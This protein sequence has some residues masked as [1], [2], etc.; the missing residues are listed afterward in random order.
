MELC[1]VLDHACNLRCR[2]C[3]TGSKTPRP[4]SADVVRKAIDLALAQHTGWLSITLFGGEPLLT[5]GILHVVEAI[6]EAALRAHEHPVAL[7]WSLDTNGTRL[8]ESALAWLAPPRRATVFVSFDG[9][10]VVHDANRIDARGRGTHRHVVEGIRRMRMAGIPFEIVAVVGPDTAN[11]LGSSL[12]AMFELQ[13]ARISLQANLYA[14]WDGRSLSD[15]DV[16]LAQAVEVWANEFRRGRCPIVEPLHSK[17]LSHLIGQAPQPRRC[18][19]ATCEFAVAPS[20]R[21]Y[22]CA[23]MVGEDDREALVIGDVERGF[24]SERVR[25]LRHEVNRAADGC[26]ACSLKERCSNRCGCRQL[27][28]SGAL[29]AVTS[30]LC[31]IESRWIDAADWGAE[32][33]VSERCPA[34][35]SF[36]YGGGW[37]EVARAG[38]THSLVQIRTGRNA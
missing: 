27:A 4:M 32:R 33:L 23:E 14:A 2:Y 24:D 16:G 34:F 11:A 7:R 18:E 8:D 37:G 31:E 12:G 26:S 20:G 28:S 22:P 19:L 35:M 9:T 17:V 6:A 29:G 15:F 10:E 25:A 30:T 21:I 3:Y 1:L 38:R 5:S 36:Y 13:A